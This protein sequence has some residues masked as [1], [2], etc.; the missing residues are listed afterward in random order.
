MHTKAHWV[1][2]VHE[3]TEE[4]YELDNRGNLIKKDKTVSPHHSK[5]IDQENNNLICSTPSKTD[6]D[7]ISPAII[8]GDSDVVF[9]EHPIDMDL[10]S[11]DLNVSILDFDSSTMLNTDLD[12]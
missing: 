11:L 7:F 6:D 2:F 8:L 3:A 10:I 1:T 5:S 4:Y 9:P 12:I